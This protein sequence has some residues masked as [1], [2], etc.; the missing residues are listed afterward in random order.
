MRRLYKT[1]LSTKLD[2][3]ALRA[4]AAQST[5][6]IK[7]Y[8]AHAQYKSLSKPPLVRFK[9]SLDLK[10]KV[11]KFSILN[12]NRKIAWKTTGKM[13]DIFCKMNVEDLSSAY[14]RVSLSKSEVFRL[15]KAFQGERSNEEFLSEINRF[16]GE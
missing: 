15:A 9:Y 5:G 14:T 8:I 7:M 10:S 12:S 3:M 13:V 11:D 6:R 4:R 1:S 16:G 2:I